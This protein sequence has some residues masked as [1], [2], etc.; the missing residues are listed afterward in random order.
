MDILLLPYYPR[1][2]IVGHVFCS[3]GKEAYLINEEE[4][5]CSCGLCWKVN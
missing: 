2:T 4:Y 3:C 1:N 5:A